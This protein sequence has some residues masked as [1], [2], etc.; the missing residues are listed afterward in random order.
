MMRAIAKVFGTFLRRYEIKSLD[1]LRKFE[2]QMYAEMGLDFRTKTMVD[3]DGKKSL[4][5]LTY[6]YHNSPE[7]WVVQ[8]VKGGLVY[9]AYLENKNVESDL[10]NWVNSIHKNDMPKGLKGIVE[11]ERSFY[12]TM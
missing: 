1:R 4:A 5:V 9:G 11:E 3:R 7:I 10:W 8:D 2:K 6:A 12:G